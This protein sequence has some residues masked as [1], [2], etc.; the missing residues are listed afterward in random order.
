MILVKPSTT[1]LAITP[2][3]LELIEEAGRTCYKSEDK[4]TKETAPI[5]VASILKR[6]HESVIEHASATVRKHQYLFI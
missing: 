5:F 2:W 4:I 6:K 1:V 3:A